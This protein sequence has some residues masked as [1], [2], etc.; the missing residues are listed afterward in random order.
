[1]PDTGA[2]RNLILPITFR[3]I[4]EESRGEIL[5]CLGNYIAQIEHCPSITMPSLDGFDEA[6]RPPESAMLSRSARFEGR[7]LDRHRCRSRLIF[8]RDGVPKAA[9]LDIA[10]Y[11]HPS[12]VFAVLDTGLNNV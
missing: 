7:E 11:L 10:F 3:Y 5:Q 2:E 9:I 4:S 6:F 1:M 12:G 8:Y